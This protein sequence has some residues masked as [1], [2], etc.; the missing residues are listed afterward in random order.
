MTFRT[1]ILLACLVVAVAPL[2]L[3][4]LGAR[5]AVRDR[6]SAQFE[7]RVSILSGL[8]REDLAQ[9][10]RSLEGR[11]GALATR[12]ADDAMLRAA[13]VRQR[14]RSAV[15]D[16][17]S[18]VMP[19]AGLDYLLL[20]DSAGVVL[21]SGHFR[22]EYD[23][24]V[25]GMEMLASSDVPVLVDAR[26]PAG[27]F[28]ALVRAHRFTVGG[29]T[30][31]LAGGEEVD[32]AFLQRLTRDIGR[33][34]T[35]SLERD[36]SV[37]ARRESVAAAQS[38]AIRDEFSIPSIDDAGGAGVP[39][40]AHLVVIHSLAPL[41]SVLRRMDLLL[42]MAGGTAIVVSTLMA[43]AITARVNRPLEEL[44]RKSATVDLDRLD[45]SFSTARQDE[46]GSLARLLD[47]MMQRLRSSVALLRE[48][49]R[50]AAVGDMA[51]QVNHDI[52]NGLVPMR[53]VVRH[54]GEVAQSSPEEVGTV[55][56]ERQG[57]LEGSIAYLEGLAS[58]YARLTPHARERV[59]D[60]SAVVRTLLRDTANARVHA[61]VARD[62]LY[63]SADPVALR[64]VLENLLVNALE[65]LED[66]MGAVQV[67]A[68]AEPDGDGA[69]VI[70]SVSD[71][72][73]GMTAEAVERAF[74]D[75]Y[76]TKELGTGLGLSIVRRLVSDMGGRIRVESTPG[77]GS[78]FTLEL[79][80]VS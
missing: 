11:L 24:S 52:R 45:V 46:L 57:T 49:E 71:E 5:L 38:R 32:R 19:A 63:V 78:T 72:G 7:A 34:L 60:V 77:V 70:I 80:A 65:S 58:N 50:R 56:V 36:S 35:I 53:N 37:D 62:G 41:R 6:L 16:Y 1:R 31:V 59:V 67:A 9:L 79:P 15:L 64:R 30:F 4:A 69:R 12:I 23:R 8:I 17:A 25:P 27:P 48:T 29:R 28:L 44:A 68:R 14:D 33:D 42:A 39:G 2:L 26:R 75:F 51:R 73:T 18:D 55:F 74:D 21:S 43:R 40:N 13:L 54:L 47:A 10:S 20:L 61:N 22:N 76:T 3:F 66:G